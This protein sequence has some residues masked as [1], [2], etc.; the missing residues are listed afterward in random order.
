MYNKEVVGIGILGLGNVGGG[1]LSILDNNKSFIE[2]EIFPKK[3]KIIAISDLYDRKKPESGKGY[4]FTTNAEEIVKHPDVDIVVEAIGGEYPAYDLIKKALQERKHVVTPN[5]EVVAKHGYQLLEIAEQNNVQLLFEPSVASAI[6]ILGSIVNI[7][8]SCPLDE[9]SGI[10]NGTTNYILDSMLENNMTKEE[11]LKKAQEMGYAEAD[12]S[13][14]ID[15]V[16]TLYKIFI[17]A[18]LG[19][20]GRLE[21][22]HIQYSG[23]NKITLEDINL[24]KQLNYRIKLVA[25]ARKELNKV[26]IKVRPAL[27]EEEHLLSNIHGADNGIFL[28][29]NCYGNLFLSGP[30]AGGNAAGSMIVSDIVKIVRN[31]SS[32]DFSF[33]TKSGQKLNIEKLGKE[34][35]SYFLRIKLKDN[36]EILESLKKSLLEKGLLI[37]PPH[38]VIEIKQKNS[39]LILGLITPLID[40]EKLKEAIK[41]IEELSYIEEISYLDVY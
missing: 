25:T 6:P 38:R 21:L 26:D 16:D 11:A 32:F 17:L 10:L 19:F 39:Y 28:T 30:G 15:G 23:I 4:F 24:A 34:K 12:P 8:T 35:Y 14:D 31:P 7:L 33:L 40:G 2:R 5:K 13:K 27:I 3:I 9:I 29:G 41:N 18:S 22:D 20:R 37:E 36:A 1:T